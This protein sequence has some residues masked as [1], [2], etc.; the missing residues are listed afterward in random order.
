MLPEHAH[1]SPLL[2]GLS[3]LSG[4]HPLL[5]A[6]GLALE[7]RRAGHPRRLHAPHLCQHAGGLQAPSEPGE[8]GL[9]GS[10]FGWSMPESRFGMGSIIMSVFLG[11]SVFKCNEKDI[12]DRVTK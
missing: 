5:G 12:S 7:G 4:R 3:E 9:H 6:G 11:F 8:F 10:A 1:L 2:A